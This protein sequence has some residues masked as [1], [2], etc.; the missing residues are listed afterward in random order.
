MMIQ[1]YRGDLKT[2]KAMKLRPVAGAGAES[3]DITLAKGQAALDA[4]TRKT[5]CCAS[6]EISLL[7]CLPGEGDI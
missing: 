6:S 1:Q 5:L 2:G 7:G 4:A 3:S